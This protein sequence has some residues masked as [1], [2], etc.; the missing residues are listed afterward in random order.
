MDG[1]ARL[2]LIESGAM[3]IA[4]SQGR[5]RFP[6]RFQLL[7]AMNPCPCGYLGDP[8]RECGTCDRRQIMR[9]QG[10]I[11]GPL[12]DRLDIQ[13]EAR[14]DSFLLP[15]TPMKWGADSA[16]IKRHV[17]LCRQLQHKRQ[18]C[19]N[20]QMRPD[21]AKQH[22]RLPPKLKELFANICERLDFS[23]RSFQRILLV[24]RTLAD[25]DAL[26]N[27]EEKHIKEA[28]TY[29]RIDHFRHI[30]SQRSQLHG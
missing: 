7:A 30:A 5:A 11:S 17:Q 2:S 9:Y 1:A 24:S 12:L 6:A 21:A 16:E 25:L 20:A 8:K 13:V 18:G 4:R 23:R 15:A 19:P 28:L 26:P 27:I 3:Y 14:R 10:K 22:C 29:R